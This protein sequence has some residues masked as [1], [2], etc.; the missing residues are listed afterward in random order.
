MAEN[1]I[2]FTWWWSLWSSL[3]S[4]VWL[5]YLKYLWH[6]MS[7]FHGIAP[8]NPQYTLVSFPTMQTRCTETWSEAALDASV[9]WFVEV[10]FF[11]LVPHS[12]LLTYGEIRNYRR[13]FQRLVVNSGLWNIYISMFTSHPSLLQCFIP[14]FSIHHAIHQNLLTF[15]IPITK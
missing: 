7:F 3:W 8:F 9:V 1:A 4:L 6:G 14:G 10:G 2:C 11:M 15:S 5:R 12:T 13:N